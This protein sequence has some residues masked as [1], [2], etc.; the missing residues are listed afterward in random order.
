[1]EPDV[2]VHAAL[3]STALRTRP[4]ALAAQR[5]R[6]SAVAIL[7]HLLVQRSEGRLLQPAVERPTLT[8]NTATAAAAGTAAGVVV[9]VGVAIDGLV[10][11]YREDILSL[12][13]LAKQ[14][15]EPSAPIR[16]V[17][18]TTALLVSALQST[19][20]SANGQTVQSPPARQ[21]LARPHPQQQ[22]RLATV[23]AARRCCR[24]AS[25]FAV[26]LR[27]STHWSSARHSAAPSRGSA[28]PVPHSRSS[29]REQL[30]SSDASR[31]VA[32]WL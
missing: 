2:A 11:M 22:G 6:Q 19:S 8:S 15:R 27:S 30:L 13:V 21:P 31:G 32:S 7:G 17:V 23:A 14:A 24:G 28:Q 16:R 3:P 9:S 29:E 18:E 1:M 4:A 25:L 20:G 10:K 12:R 26:Q 5:H